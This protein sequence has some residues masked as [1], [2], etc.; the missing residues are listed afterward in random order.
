MI[1]IHPPGD[2]PPVTLTKTRTTASGARR[3]KKGDADIQMEAAKVALELKKS[4]VVGNANGKTPEEQLS[5]YMLLENIGA[6]MDVICDIMGVS[7]S[8]VRK[9]KA[10]AREMY[11]S[12]LTDSGVMGIVGVAFHRL[13]EMS[14]KTMALIAGLNESAEDAPVLLQAIKALTDIETRKVELLVKT[15]AV[16]VTRKV[17]ISG[18]LDGSRVGDPSLMSGQVAARLLNMITED[19]YEPEPS[20]EDS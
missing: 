17:E 10:D 12:A 19:L 15:G 13:D 8:R 14:R 3:R 18:A 4:G 16:K 6:P 9:L 11:I 1:H 7:I 20:E 2:G 5:Q